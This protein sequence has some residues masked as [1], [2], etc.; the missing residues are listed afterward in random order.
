MHG[1]RDHGSGTRKGAEPSESWAGRPPRPVPLRGSLALRTIIDLASQQ[2]G[3]VSRAQLLEAGVTPDMVDRR[4]KMGLLRQL[5]RG[6]Y[7]VGPVV[8]PR[9]R[10]MA[11]VLAC[12]EAVVSHW[13]AAAMWQLLLGPKDDRV[14]V[15][16]P[17]VDRTRKPGIR[18][19]GVRPLLPD[20]VTRLDGVPVTTAARTLFDITS[21]AE[22]RQLE[23]ALTEALAR[24]LTTREAL[25]SQ[26]DRHVRRPGTGRLSALLQAGAEPMLTRSEAEER[27]LALIRSGGLPAPKVNGVVCGYEVD[28]F[29]P[30][31]GLVVEIDGREYHS[32][33]PMFEGDR[34]RDRRL[35]A[36]GLRVIRI[37]WTQLVRESNAVLVQVT[38]ALL[39]ATQPI[40]VQASRPA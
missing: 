3:V 4:L 5:H 29:W 15:S 6:V 40:Q 2:H 23:R 7:Q 26:V 31:Q 13:T 36:A 27:F 30:K 33:D 16:T 1:R 38:Q 11:A 22:R 18:V 24:R 35:T 25:L 14:H 20:E 34:R 9:A 39:R 8:S 12:R 21:S 10:A 32:S 37:T 19:H 28:C 17:R